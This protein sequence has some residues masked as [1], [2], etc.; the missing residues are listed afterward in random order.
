MTVGRSRV[1]AE[2]AEQRRE[3][4]QRNKRA[5]DADRRDDHKKE[6]KAE[7]V[8]RDDAPIAH[9]ETRVEARTADP[10]VYRR[11]HSSSF[12]LDEQK[13]LTAF[14]HFLPFT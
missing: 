12:F 4:G 6:R 9:R 13:V 14:I 3:R 10:L 5:H 11:L 1:A 7:A 2:S 8:Q